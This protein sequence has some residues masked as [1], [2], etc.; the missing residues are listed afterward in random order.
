[1]FKHIMVPVDL[2]HADKLGK[3]LDTAG[4]IGK[5][6][7]A[8]VTYVGVTAE[9]PTGL[10]HNPEE[11][12]ANLDKFAKE[13]SGKHGV[14]ADSKAYASH[15]PTV[16]L[17]DTLLKAAADIGADCIVMAS[18]IPNITDRLWPSNGGTVAQKAKA[19]VFVVR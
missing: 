12:A 1:M 5:T 11:Y 13:Q 19:S 3:A 17:D 15:D 9:T 4:L 6:S 18:H 16:D 7:G 10:G 8:S 14:S 2:A